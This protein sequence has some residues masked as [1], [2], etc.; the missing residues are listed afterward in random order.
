MHPHETLLR[1][2]FE[3]FARRDAESM[4]H[5]YHPD[6]FF[7]DPIFTALRGPDVADMWR[8]LLGRAKDL[9]V[10]VDEIRAD[11]DGGEAR[12]TARYTFVR[13]GRRV[14]NRIESLF[15]FRDGLI[16]RQYDRFPLWRWAAQALGPA[17]LLF[18]WSLPL[19]WKV[20][21]DAASLLER[22]ARNAGR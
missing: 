5:C 10:S 6:A 19:K 21:R 18:G 7:S 22:F 2:F 9:E 11:A 13:T 17:G 4:A 20:R 1:A 16:V 3:A 8:M 12:W 15:A 14:V